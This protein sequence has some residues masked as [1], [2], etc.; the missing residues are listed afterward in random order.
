V[1]LNKRSPV[2]MSPTRMAAWLIGA[3]LLFVGCSVGV[4]R[5]M[6]RGGTEH[7]LLL[8][9]RTMQYEEREG[10]KVTPYSLTMFYSGGVVSK[11]F[12]A[13][14]KGVDFGDCMFVSQGRQVWFSTDHPITAIKEMPDARQL[15]VDENASQGDT[16]EDEDTGTQTTFLGY[17]NVTVPAGTYD[18]CYKTITTVVPALPDSLR[19]W[20]ASGLI[21]EKVYARLTKVCQADI[22][23]WFASGVGLVKEQLGSP[24]HV[25][26]LMAVL[27]TGVGKID[28]SAM[29]KT[30]IPEPETK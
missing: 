5:V 12:D 18:H 8:N 2:I 11:V 3:A 24:D 16:W 4:D 28:S 26:E 17:E 21:G 25:R 27:E 30:Q 29:L 23:R 13:K 19:A 7:L 14:F 1:L 15:W 22:I 6:L 20:R 10:N 9:G